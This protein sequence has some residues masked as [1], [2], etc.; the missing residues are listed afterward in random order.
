[1]P[2]LAGRARSFHRRTMT[3]RSVDRTNPASGKSCRRRRLIVRPKVAWCSGYVAA[4]TGAMPMA[5]GDR[6]SLPIASAPM[7]RPALEIRGPTNIAVLPSWPEASQD[8]VLDLPGPCR[9]SE[10]ARA[11][12]SFSTRRRWGGRSERAQPSGNLAGATSGSSGTS[13]GPDGA[14]H[15]GPWPRAATASRLDRQ[16]RSSVPA[17]AGSPM[18]HAGR[19]GAARERTTVS[20]TERPRR[21]GTRAKRRVTARRICCRREAAIL[22]RNLPDEPRS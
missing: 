19:A 22:S 17:G 2:S 20:V 14:C 16:R 6:P 12:V 10:E 1:M 3:A 15:T 9:R 18:R 5:R 8:H 11:H 7:P 21:R 4:P 13:C